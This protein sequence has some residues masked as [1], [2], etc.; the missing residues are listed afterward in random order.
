MD[1]PAL[2]TVDTGGETRNLGFS[3]EGPSQVKINC[4]NNGDGTADVDYVPTVAG[5]YALHILCDSEDIPGSPFMAQ[6]IPKT[7]YGPGLEEVVTP[8]EETQFTIDSFQAGKAPLDVIFMDDY[9]EV[10]PKD[11]NAIQEPGS[12]FRVTVDDPTDPNKVK[13]C[14]P[15]IEDGNKTETPLDFTVDS[16]EAGPG[17]LEI[18]I[19]D[20]DDKIQEVPITVNDTGDRTFIPQSPM[21]VNVKTDI[22][23][24]K[25]QVLGQDDEVVEDCTN[26]FEVDTIRLEQPGADGNAAVSYTPSKEGKPEI[27][28]TCEG[29][30]IQGSPFNVE[31]NTGFDPKKVSAFEPDLE[32]GLCDEPNQFTTETRKA[33]KGDPGLSTEVPAEAKMTDKDNRDES[34]NVDSV[35][36]VP[37]KYDIF[38]KLEDKNIPDPVVDLSRKEFNGKSTPSAGQSGLADLSK[39]KMKIKVIKANLIGKSDPYAIINYEEQQFQTDTVRNSREPNWDYE[40]EID[41]PE[42]SIQVVGKDKSLGT[43]NISIAELAA[44]SEAEGRWYPLTGV[45]SGK[46]LLSAEFL[47]LA[48]RTDSVSMTER[49]VEKKEKEQKDVVNQLKG[50]IELKHTVICKLLNVII[51]SML[52]MS[53]K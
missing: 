40:L 10:K 4:N 13:V 36:T 47:R 30:P 11:E 19:T 44:I 26:D 38:D 32:G 33:G 27:N 8:N 43:V 45:K 24:K 20:D 52:K 51:E 3:I 1:L 14:G 31:A 15:G 49:T 53:Q 9:G 7:D 17:D 6:I 39:G 28:L 34:C 46:I 42:I 25:T 48:G 21:T 37:G 41:V 29:D 18:N 50:Q 2:F 16:K 23:L 5:K 22:D 35:Q 12:P